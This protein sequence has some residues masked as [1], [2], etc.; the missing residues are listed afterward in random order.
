MSR[1]SAHGCEFSV[2]ILSPSAFPRSCIKFAFPRAAFLNCLERVN[3][4]AQER[5]ARNTR[6]SLVKLYPLL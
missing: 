2:P 3:A 5:E 4:G 6:P 1:L